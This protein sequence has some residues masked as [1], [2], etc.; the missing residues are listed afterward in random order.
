VKPAER[1]S[2]AVAVLFGFVGIVCPIVYD[3]P[4]NSVAQALGAPL[5]LIQIIMVGVVTL[6]VGIV[7]AVIL[8][9]TRAVDNSG[10]PSASVST[11]TDADIPSSLVD[12]CIVKTFAAFE[13]SLASRCRELLNEHELVRKNR[14]YHR[15]KVRELLGL[16][17]LN[18]EMPWFQVS[19]NWP[20]WRVHIE[21]R[22]E[23]ERKLRE[24]HDILGSRWPRAKYV[25]ALAGLKMN[26]LHDDVRKELNALR[27]KMETGAE[28]SQ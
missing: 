12:D 5:I 21:K 25:I 20:N 14:R 1:A 22:A 17:L 26:V 19:K 13:K 11:R 7:L 15:Q 9:R 24:I 4:A 23:Y 3:W 6:L 8:H 16:D 28:P 2:I 27:K 10:R 18:C